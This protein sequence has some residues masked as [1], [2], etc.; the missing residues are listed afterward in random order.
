MEQTL[1]QVGELLLG[2]VPTILLLLMLYGFY[3]ALV[4]RPLKKI[5]AER[6][7]RTEGAIEKARADISAAESKTFEY[8]AKLREAKLAVF[9]A[10]EARRQQAEDAR[11]EAVAEAR[12]RADAL[13]HQARKQVQEDATAARQGLQTEAER[14]AAEIIRAV[15]QPAGR[16]E[17]R[18]P[19]GQS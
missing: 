6:R 5:L 2:A 8:E 12:K 16:S 10:Q 1:K 15:L 17:A 7:S 19:G 13:I 14:L 18:A 11:A 4:Y 3:T 9:R